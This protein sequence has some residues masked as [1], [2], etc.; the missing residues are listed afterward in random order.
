MEPDDAIDPAWWFDLPADRIA[1]YPASRR[2]DARLLRLPLDGHPLADAH[3][4]DLPGLLRRG[5]LLVVN[6]SRVVPARLHARR[7]TG[8]RV[9]LLLLGMGPGPVAALARPARKLRRGEVLTLADGVTATVVTPAEQGVVAIELSADP[10][11][12]MDSQGE[13]PLPPYLDRG[14]EPDDRERYQ[15]VYADRPGSAAA[16]TA[17]LHFT[18]A[19]FAELQAAGV[20]V[21]RVTLHVGLGTFR[22]LRP[23]D[24]A[25]G[26]LHEEWREVPQATV[27]AIRRTRERGGRV[28]AVGTTSVRS[29]ES[30]TPEGQR[31]PTASRG[32]TDLF[33]RPPYGMRCVD[34]LLTNFHLPG[35]SLVMLV[36]CL[37]GRE[38][39]LGAYTHAVD[40]GYRFYSYGDAMLLL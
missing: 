4:R 14:E 34:G 9:E 3:V 13:L 31:V 17:G 27:D 20:E 12:V 19:L 40:S 35:S 21:A 28:I 15:T 11:E 26:T 29:L 36:A 1:R 39:L 10:L 18:D 25:R 7:A 2:S 22:P 6:D 24:V 37:V 23:E 33:L 8:G 16:P 38:R 30:A 32:P 5:D